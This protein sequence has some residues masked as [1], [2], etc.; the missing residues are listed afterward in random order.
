MTDTI[1]VRVRAGKTH[2]AFKGGARHTFREGEEL[3]VSL[4]SFKNAA[5]VFEKVEETAEAEEASEDNSVKNPGQDPKLVA[6]PKVAPKPVAR[7]A[8]TS[9]PVAKPVAAPPAPTA[10]TEGE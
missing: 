2:R 1:K 3:E 5:H 7:P 8:V 9:K 6:A 4:N 10:P